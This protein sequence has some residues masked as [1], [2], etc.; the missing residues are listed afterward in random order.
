M[1]EDMLKDGVVYAEVRST[2]RALLDLSQEQYIDVL[3]QRV[4]AHNG[5]PRGEQLQ[6]RVLLSINRGRSVA[7]ADA[8]VA[9]AHSARQ[10]YL[11]PPSPSVSSSSSLEENGNADTN[12]NTNVIVGIDFSGNPFLQPFETYTTAF[13]EAQRLGFRATIHAGE[14][15]ALADVEMG[16]ILDY[17]HDG[18][19]VSGRGGGSGSSS[20]NGRSRVGHAVHIHE[21]HMQRLLERFRAG[22]RRAVPLVEIPPSS[23]MFTLKLG[24]RLDKHPTLGMWLTEGYPVAICVDDSG[25]FNTT[26]TRELEL[27]RETYALSHAQVVSLAA[28]P[29]FHIFDEDPLETLRVIKLFYA[30]AERTE[31]SEGIEGCLKCALDSLFESEGGLNYVSDEL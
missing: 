2:P 31:G 23:N 28:A 1:V 8:L 12:T 26:L 21:R 11:S 6:L 19:G 24:G 4:Q 3:V 7:D 10:T 15:P 9:M 18:G 17:L 14:V 5:S 27:V 22:G 30:F 20:G 25:V 16:F 13:A 29:I